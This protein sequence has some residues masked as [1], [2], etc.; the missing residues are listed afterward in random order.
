M[1]AFIDYSWFKGLPRCL[2]GKHLQMQE[3]QET[4]VLSLGQ[5]EPLEEEI[6]THLSIL[7]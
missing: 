7:A 3:M 2:S 5:E 4:Q 1:K 6:A